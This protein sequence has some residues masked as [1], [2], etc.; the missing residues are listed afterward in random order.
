MGLATFWFSKWQVPWD[1]P[2]F[3]ARRFY[4][5]ASPLGL[6]TFE[7]KKWQVP[8]LATFYLMK[9]QV[10][11]DLPLF[12]PRSGKSHGTC[13][14]LMGLATFLVKK[15]QVPWQVPCLNYMG[16]GQDH[17]HSVISRKKC[18]LCDVIVVHCLHRFCL[19]C[20]AC[21]PLEASTPPWACALPPT[22]TSL[23]K[24]STLVSDPRAKL[25][26]FA[27]YTTPRMFKI[28]LANLQLVLLLGKW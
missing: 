15:W 2:L 14:F 6:A 4:E 27:L 19:L 23:F 12:N 26:L 7:F 5:V 10:P 18:T 11:W 28:A 3:N 21:L 13:H 22:L 20:T 8:G 25:Y 16:V 1:L 24:R 17:F 9:W